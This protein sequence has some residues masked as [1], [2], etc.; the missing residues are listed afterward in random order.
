MLMANV[1]E[2]EGRKQEL[3]ELYRRINRLEPK[4]ETVIY[5][6]GVLLYELERFEE[7]ADWLTRYAEAHPED[8]PVQE[9]LFDCYL[10]TEKEDQAFDAAERILE[11]NPD[12][13]YPYGFIVDYLSDKGKYDQIVERLKPAVETHPDAGDLKRNL[14]VAY[15]RAGKTREAVNLGAELLEDNPA[16]KELL[17]F[18]FDGYR[19]LGDAAS[20]LETAEALASLEAVDDDIYGFIFDQLSADEK[21]DRIIE[22]MEGAVF[23][24]PERARLR[25]YLV[26][27]YLKTGNEGGAAEQ[28]EEIVRLRPDDIAMVLNLARLQEKRGKYGKAAEAY[29]QAMTLDPQN[30]EAAEGYLRTRLKGVA[31]D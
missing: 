4:N 30:E 5:N 10:K 21:F 12:V 7:C 25:E 28:M 31:G 23:K 20:A 27:A 19:S 6:L 29:K 2:R 22:I 24:A 9:M 1:A 13:L 15:T 26:V 11:L 17:E 3:V 16:D 18:L 8:A 14:M